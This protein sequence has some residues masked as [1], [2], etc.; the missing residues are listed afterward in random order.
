VSKRRKVWWIVGG[1]LAC[2]IISAVLLLPLDSS[3]DAQMKARLDAVVEKYGFER[4]MNYGGTSANS[5]D[6]VVIFRTGALSS[7]QTEDVVSMLVAD[8]SEC[9]AGKPVTLQGGDAYRI[10]LREG[11]RRLKNVEVWQYADR[12]NSPITDLETS[13]C[14][15]MERGIPLP[16]RNCD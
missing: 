10:E 15:H 5:R 1:V 2:I 11:F 13:I 9:K 6:D 16:S 12:P 14:V 7:E 4:E 3:A 8:C